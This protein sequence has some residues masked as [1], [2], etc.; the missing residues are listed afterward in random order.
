M[1]VYVCVCVWYRAEQGC[2]ALHLAPYQWQTVGALAPALAGF[3]P[4][5]VYLLFQTWA[6]WDTCLRHT[7]QG[8]Y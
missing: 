2:Y 1:R 4:V 8:S 7:S 6:T 5:C 3:Q